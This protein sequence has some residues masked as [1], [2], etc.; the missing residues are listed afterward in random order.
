MAG[1]VLPVNK[2]LNSGVSPVSGRLSHKWPSI[3]LDCWWQNPPKTSA[4][5]LLM[6]HRTKEQNQGATA[7]LQQFYITEFDNVTDCLIL[8]L[9]SDLGVRLSSSCGCI[10][11]THDSIKSM[12]LFCS[13]AFNFRS[14]AQRIAWTVMWTV[15][16]WNYDCAFQS[17]FMW[18]HLAQKKNHLAKKIWVHLSE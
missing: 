7:R 12:R 18:N 5:F 17:H 11:S 13:A 6:A 16:I 10:F 14:C 9:D 2:I 1:S 8:Y 15:I 4:I 3:S